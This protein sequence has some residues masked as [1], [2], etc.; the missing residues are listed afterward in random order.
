MGDVSVELW[1]VGKVESL[2]SRD[3]VIVVIGDLVL[4]LLVF[5]ELRDK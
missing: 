1:R 2:L 4:W 3:K 5:G